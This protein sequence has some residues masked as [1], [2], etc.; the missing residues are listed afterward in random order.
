MKHITFQN[1][2]DANKM[3][4]QGKNHIEV[5]VFLLSRF[6]NLTKQEIRAMPCSEVRLLTDELEAYM[7]NENEK[8]LKS[9]PVKKQEKI[10][11]RFDLLDL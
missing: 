3:I 1:M 5:Q 7:D 4:E 2:I 11:N 9:K 8:V 6:H 10:G